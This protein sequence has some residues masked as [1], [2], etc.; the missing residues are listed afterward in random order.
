MAE[1]EEDM[2]AEDQESPE[3]GDPDPDDTQMNQQQAGNGTA[4]E[5]SQE[6]VCAAGLGVGRERILGPAIKYRRPTCRLGGRTW[7]AMPT[8]S[9]D[10]KFTASAP[11]G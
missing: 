10:L 1:M 5:Q 9:T 8:R 2:L 7:V 11:H 6:E 3:D 4:D